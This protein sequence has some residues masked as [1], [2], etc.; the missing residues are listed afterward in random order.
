M[1][2]SETW[3]SPLRTLDYYAL[4]AKASGKPDEPA[5]KGSFEAKTP[6][7]FADP[8]NGV[9]I[10][11]L[12][13]NQE[14]QNP[15]ACL[16]IGR[17]HAAGPLRGPR[18][19]WVSGG[20]GASAALALLDDVSTWCG[21]PVNPNSIGDIESILANGIQGSMP[22]LE[23]SLA[24]PIYQQLTM[25]VDCCCGGC[26]AKRKVSAAILRSCSQVSFLRMRA[27]QVIQ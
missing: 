1:N 25:G 3:N 12:N 5:A 19:L 13:W 16:R 23:A 6:T 26:A 15:G 10:I 20:A 27:R 8:P 14:K 11:F 22:G 2:G 7:V 21:Y 9:I 4:L 24:G 18:S 17:G